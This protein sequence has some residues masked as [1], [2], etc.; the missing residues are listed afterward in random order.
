MGS[1]VE[2]KYDPFINQV[3]YVNPNMTRTP[4][5]LTHNLFINELIVSSSRVISDFAIPNSDY[6]S[7]N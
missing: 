4:L 5:T 1:H 6:S 7:H 3:S 2:H